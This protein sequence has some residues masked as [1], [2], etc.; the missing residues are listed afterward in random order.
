MNFFGLF[1]LLLSNVCTQAMTLNQVLAHGY[2]E[3]LLKSSGTE[4]SEVDVVSAL[5]ICSDTNLVKR[6]VEKLY[7]PEVMKQWSTTPLHLAIQ[8]YDPE[9]LKILL[10]NGFPVDALDKEGKTALHQAAALRGTFLEGLQILCEAKANMHKR[11]PQTGETP[12]MLMVKAPRGEY[13]E[14]A[15]VLLQHGSDPYICNDSHDNAMNIAER[16]KNYYISGFMRGYFLYNSPLKKRMVRV[17]AKRLHQKNE[18]QPKLPF[19]IWAAI[20]QLVYS[21]PL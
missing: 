15:R 11:L 8:Y 2:L 9:T 1:L 5:R 19:E 18:L 10:A 3:K 21:E 16:H 12:L 6:A 4:H 17:L 13:I 20:A 7:D 14:G